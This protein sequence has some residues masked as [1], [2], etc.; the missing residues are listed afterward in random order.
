MDIRISK[1]PDG[2]VKYPMHNHKGFEIMIY[3][4]GEGFLATDGGNIPFTKGTI[5]VVPAGVS[6]G[7]ISEY[8][9]C[10]ISVEGDFSNY[11]VFREIKVLYDNEAGEGSQ[12]ARL[13]YENRLDGGAYLDALCHSYLHFLVR[14][15]TVESNMHTSVAHLMREISRRA[16]DP[17][18][19]LPDLLAESGYS[20]DHIRLRFRQITGKTPIEY[21]T[22]LR[23]SH[24]R[25]LIDVY[26][27]T[28]T[29]SEI[30][31]RCGYLDYVYFSKRFKQVTGLSPREYK[32]G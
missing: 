2:A 11:F 24:A 23:I 15:M 28:L 12:L 30:A 8:G 21:L 4:D 9:F 16:L 27:D 13:I 18:I 5:V 29:L 19:D 6:H 3:L 17:D 31:Y 32:N 14:N 26:K 22:E 25:F 10:N 20:E 7:S 1:T